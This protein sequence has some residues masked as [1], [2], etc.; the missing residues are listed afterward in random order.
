MG[1]LKHAVA[2]LSLSLLGQGPLAAEPPAMGAQETAPYATQQTAQQ[3][4]VIL[5]IKPAELSI[6][7][8][9]ADESLRRSDASLH[10]LDA[11][12]NRLFLALQRRLQ[13]L[14]EMFVASDREAEPV[15]V[16]PFRIGIDAG[17]I[18]RGSRL[19]DLHSADFDIS[20]RL[21]NLER[22]FDVFITT[23]ALSESNL[24]SA[25]DTLRAGLRFDQIELVDFE[26]GVKLD[27][28]PVGFVAIRT[29]RSLPFDRWR[30]EPFAK[31]FVD[32]DDGFGAAGSVVIDRW[33][34]RQLFRSQSSLRWLERRGETSW[35]QTL[36]YAQV[37]SVISADRNLSRV[38]NRDLGAATGVRLQSG[39]E[40]WGRSDFHELGLF[41]KRPLRNDWLYFS[42]E[43]LVRFE[44]ER[45]WR[46][47]PGI[48]LGIDALFWDIAR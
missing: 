43:P 23:D 15:P 30:I 45:N 24:E 12:H 13:R 38:R 37:S 39:G 18:Q 17:V 16:S 19:D 14:D 28:P 3:A 48:K 42:V 25:R 7:S 41:W 44:A 47:D 21:P 9:L 36:L 33:Q 5:E 31:L 46:A 10:R 29:G 27:A 20:L 1:R 34:Q 26:M 2:L 22:R 32:T 40:I 8:L 35:S 4:P 11:A 6:A